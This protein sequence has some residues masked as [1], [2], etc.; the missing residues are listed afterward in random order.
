MLHHSFSLSSWVRP[1]TSGTLF[2]VNRFENVLTGGEGIAALTVGK[3]SL[4]LEIE[5]NNESKL[6]LKSPPLS[7][8]LQ[9]W[10]Q[11][12]VIISFKTKQA[13]IFL[14]DE[15]IAKKDYNHAFRDNPDFPHIIGAQGSFSDAKQH[16]KG[17]IFNF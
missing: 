7:L 14:N 2:S 5:E 10:I 4:I 1:T 6:H 12:T 15:I 8:G 11:V 17:L 9:N 16:Y 3:A 13:R